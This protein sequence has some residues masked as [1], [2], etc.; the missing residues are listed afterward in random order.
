[1]DDA[2]EQAIKLSREIIDHA[3]VHLNEI[4]E[5]ENLIKI[6]DQYDVNALQVFHD[7]CVLGTLRASKPEIGVQLHGILCPYLHERLAKVNLN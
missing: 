5:P 1:M 2:L 4:V 7:I 6:F 3:K